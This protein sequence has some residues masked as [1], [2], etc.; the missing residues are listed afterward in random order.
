MSLPIGM[1][2]ISNEAANRKKDF[3]THYKSLLECEDE[4]IKP[5]VFGSNYSNPIY[6]CNF[7]MR[8]FPFTYISIEIQGKGF[9][10]PN[11]LFIS[12]KDSFINSS[13]QDGDVRELIPEFFFLPEMFKNVNKLN[14]GKLVNG[15][16]VNDVLTPC[17]NNPY[18]FI[19]TMRNCLESNNISYKLHEWINLIFGFKQRGKEAEKAYNIYKE[20]CYQEIIDIN[21]FDNKSDKLREAE[22]GLVPNQLMIKDC[23]KKEKKEVIKKGKFITDKDCD[24]RHYQCKFEIEKNILKEIDGLNLVK[25]SSFSQDKLLLL[26]GGSIFVEV[27]I[28][29]SLF[30]KSYNCEILNIIEINRYYHKMK[31]FYNPEKPDSKVMKFC[32]KGRTIIF[33]G[34]YDGKILIKSTLSEQKTNYKIDIPFKDNS[35]IVALEI[36]QDDEFAFFGNEI[37]NIRIMKLNSNIKESKMDILISDHLSSISYIHCNTDLNLWISASIDGYIN[38]YTLPLSKLLRSLK[39][40]TS[41]CD[42]AFLS[43]SP[44]PSIIVIGEENK[45]SEIFIYSIN[46]ELYLRQKEKYIIKNPLILKD[47]NYNEFLAYVMNQSIIIRVLP[48]LI[49]QTI[50]DDIP[51]L[52][53]IC[54]SDD[55][56]TLFAINRSGKYIEIIKNTL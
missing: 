43:S 47:L 48:N 18:D 1:L 40:D 31:E 44:L 53:S 39:V 17:K 6:V 5:Y 33:G 38:L 49:K 13:T 51:D 34:F 19:M 3:C 15:E 14:M 24:L 30:D 25:A 28:S 29:Y 21:N 50:I 36:D 27:K 55:Q 32:H 4:L 9:D 16:Q 52:F 23:F 8:L 42:Y 41:Y 20:S 35:P 7:L 11:R 37:G 45:T 56:K 22:F 12:V 54:Q 10:D 46:G 2:E 26:L